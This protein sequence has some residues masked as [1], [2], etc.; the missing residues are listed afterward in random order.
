MPT[1]KQEPQ[2][3]P[4]KTIANHELRKPT[5]IAEDEASDVGIILTFSTLNNPGAIKFED[6]GGKL[7][8]LDHK[9]RGIYILRPV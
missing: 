2:Q 8:Y 4:A 5:E 3:D 6:D 9:G 7:F 1:P